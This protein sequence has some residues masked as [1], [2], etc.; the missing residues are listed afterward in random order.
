MSDLFIGSSLYQ[1]DDRGRFNIPSKMRKNRDGMLYNDLIV[2]IGA[3]NSLVIFP[4]NSF[5]KYVDEFDPS[6]MSYE[7]E[8]AF[9]R[10]F[11]PMASEISLDSQGRVNVPNNLIEF[12]LITKDVRIIGVGKWIEVWNP[13]EYE[14]YIKKQQESY[15]ATARPFFSSINRPRIRQEG[16]RDS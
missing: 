5:E 10:L 7:D 1:R 13:E 6:S 16:E 4:R 11:L 14:G 8:Q 12:A 9:Y 15:D 3:N 2:T